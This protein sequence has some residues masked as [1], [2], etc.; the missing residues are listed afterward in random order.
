MELGSSLSRKSRNSGQ[1]VCFG[2]LK[3]ST[4]R[5]DRQKS[6]SKILRMSQF[7]DGTEWQKRALIEARDEI[8]MKDRMIEQLNETIAETRCDLEKKQMKSVK[9]EDEDEIVRKFEECF[10]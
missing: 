5:L 1:K 8:R 3:A 9:Y 2:G 4:S 6:S 10:V 7:Q